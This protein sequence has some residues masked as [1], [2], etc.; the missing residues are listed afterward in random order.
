MAEDHS[1]DRGELLAP[2]VEIVAAHVGN[3]AVDDDRGVPV[4]DKKLELISGDMDTRAI[5]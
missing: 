1:I 2:T 3:N 4:P 5:K